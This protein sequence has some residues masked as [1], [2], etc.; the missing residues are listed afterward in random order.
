MVGRP[1]PPPT[2]SRAPWS[3][4]RT[5]RNW[6]RRLFARSSPPPD[7]YRELISRLPIPTEEQTEKF[8]EYVVGARSWYKH[9]PRDPPGTRFV[10]FLDPNAGRA[11]VHADGRPQYRDRVNERERFHYTWMPT[12][13]YLAK[14]GHWQ[15]RSL[16][17]RARSIGHLRGA[18]VAFT[19][20][21]S[22]SRRSTSRRSVSDR[23]GRRAQPSTR[24]RYDGPRSASRVRH[25][26]DVARLGDSPVR[27]VGPAGRG[28]RGSNSST[29]PRWRLAR[30]RREE[31]RS[32]PGPPSWAPEHP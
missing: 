24:C 4:I 21:S 27:S 13:E 22:R 3:T 5:M 25:A 32:A 18:G 19:A 15:P 17:P 20:R 30:G 14:F 31:V 10:V 11:I 8:V 2:C 12:A 28:C 16:P 1:S 23:G 26:D 9:L 6:L 29:G 7:R